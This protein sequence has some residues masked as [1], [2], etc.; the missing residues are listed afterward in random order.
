MMSKFE[1][2]L[3]DMDDCNIT[4]FHDPDDPSSW[5]IRK[6]KRLLFWKRVEL[7]RWF[8]TREQAEEYARDLI[9]DCERRRR[10]AS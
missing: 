1:T 2:R 6:W 4:L 8:A 7:S 3:S 5:V 9:E 10:K